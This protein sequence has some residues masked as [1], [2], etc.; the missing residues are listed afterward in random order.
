MPNLP[1][2]NLRTPNGKSL[3]FC[4]FSKVSL[5]LWISIILTLFQPNGGGGAYL[6][7]LRSNAYTCKKSNFDH[8][9][10]FLNVYLLQ[11]QETFRLVGGP[12]SWSETSYFHKGGPLRM[13]PEWNVRKKLFSRSN[14]YISRT[15]WLRHQQ[16]VLNWRFLQDLREPFKNY[17]A[18]FFR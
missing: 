3:Q 18:D 14:S 1:G 4:T 6:L 8:F 12:L 13:V 2:P 5:I 11:G 7:P 16:W 9:C 17:L 10:I 15:K